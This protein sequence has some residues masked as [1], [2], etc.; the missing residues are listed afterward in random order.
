MRGRAQESTQGAPRVDLFIDL[1]PCGK[2]VVFLM[3]RWVDQQSIKIEPCKRPRVENDA[4]AE[5][6]VRRMVTFPGRRGPYIETKKDCHT[7]LSR[8]TREAGTKIKK[9]Y[10]GF[11]WIFD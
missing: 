8:Q 3:A 2:V 5:S 9:C 6:Q 10:G 7:K 1:G 11:I 4:A